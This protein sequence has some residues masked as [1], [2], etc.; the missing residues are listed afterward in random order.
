METFE[1]IKHLRKDILKLNQEDF[2]K[3]I[4]ISRS[5]IANIEVGRIKLTDRVISDIC[6]EFN[7]D[8]E[9]LRTGNGNHIFVQTPDD[10]LKRLAEKYN[11]NDAEY[12]FF[13]QYVK[14]DISKRRALVEFLENFTSSNNE[15]CAC[16]YED[17]SN[18]E[19]SIEERIAEA[20]REHEIK[21]LG[22]KPEQLDTRDK[23]LN[24]KPNDKSD[25]EH[26]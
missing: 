26:A 21:V 10:E 11:F 22:K 5:N 8:E 16:E 9:W 6:R 18:N 14:L 3:N 12:N 24:F 7:V 15:D 2:S 1:R 25:K 23:I 17:A 19:K 4:G 13:S 20:E